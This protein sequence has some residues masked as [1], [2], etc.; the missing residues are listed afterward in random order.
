[1]IYRKGNRQRL[2]NI[3]RVGKMNMPVRKANQTR[4][5]GSQ[6]HAFR[7]FLVNAL[8]LRVIYLT[9]FCAKALRLSA[10][11][12]CPSFLRCLAVCSCM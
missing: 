1:M 10:N 8:D 9:N 12:C 3:L 11:S 4:N 6:E 7:I 5:K 2:L